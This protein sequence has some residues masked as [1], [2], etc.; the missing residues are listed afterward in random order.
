MGQSTGGGGALKIDSVNPGTGDTGVTVT[1]ATELQVD[2]ISGLKITSPSSGVA[3]V[4]GQNASTT[5]SGVVNITTQ[6]FAGRKTFNNQTVMLAQTGDPQYGVS[7]VDPPALV[8][9]VGGGSSGDVPLAMTYTGSGGT[10]WTGFHPYIAYDVGAGGGFSEVDWL[11]NTPVAGSQPARSMYAA[12][13]A[14]DSSPNL[15]VIGPA[16]SSTPAAYAV[17]IGASRY[18]GFTGTGG[19]GDTFMGGICTAAGTGITWR[20]F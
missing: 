3:R 14:Y 15:F 5:H 10:A 11:L 7:A 17:D 13:I 9:P 20:T 12:L 19:A 16:K 1:S 6:T 2:Q 8:L 4:A 18:A